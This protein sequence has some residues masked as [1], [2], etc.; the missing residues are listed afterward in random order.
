[1]SDNEEKPQVKGEEGE[2]K[3]AEHINLKVKGQV[4]SAR[5]AVGVSHTA[6]D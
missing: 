3:E 4:R 1:M 2:G 5:S 6:I